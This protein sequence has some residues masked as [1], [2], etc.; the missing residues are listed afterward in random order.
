MNDEKLLSLS[1]LDIMEDLRL[2]NE[3]EDYMHDKSEN[4]ETIE[5]DSEE[6]LDNFIQSGGG[7]SAVI[8]G[9]SEEELDDWMKDE[10]F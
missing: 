5:L 2:M 3:L 4:L 7:K 6:D 8:T 10:K 1:E 9:Y